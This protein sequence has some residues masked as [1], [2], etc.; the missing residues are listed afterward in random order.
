M[1]RGDLH[2]IYWEYSIN[3][4]EIYIFYIFICFVI[5]FIIEK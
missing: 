1:T 5:I 3:S 2:T 4:M